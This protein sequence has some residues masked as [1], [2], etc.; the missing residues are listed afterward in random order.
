MF[1]AR[2]S[3]KGFTLVEL[4]VGITTLSVILLLM[5]GALFP[6]ASRGTD[7]WYQVRS[8]EL[9]LSFM[10]EI[11]AKA[12]DENEVISGGQIRCGDT[13][14]N[15]CTTLDACTAPQNWVEEA[16]R[17]LFDDVDDYHCLSLTGSQIKNIEGSNIGD[18]SV[19]DGFTV[20]VMVAYAG[21]D[22]DTTSVNLDNLDAKRITVTVS[23]PA[24]PEDVYA[25]QPVVFHAYRTNF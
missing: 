13:S 23:P 8:A 22:L 10:N 14:G 17:D 24:S 6:Q 7:P 21:D 5:T 3:T 20:T 1:V 9:A 11:M 2:K 19:Y 15:A 4:V 18:N 16:S 12:Y 25:S